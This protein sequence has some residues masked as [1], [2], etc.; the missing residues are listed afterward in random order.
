MKL[1][2]FGVAKWNAQK[3]DTE[4]V[5]V[6]K[7]PCHLVD[8]L[9][10]GDD[11]GPLDVWPYR[12]QIRYNECLREKL[13]KASKL[14]RL[15]EGEATGK[16]HECFKH[17]SSSASDHHVVIRGDEEGGACKEEEGGKS[18]GVKKREMKGS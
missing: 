3:S 5:R 8:W 1:G 12:N 6:G 16:G 15:R 4:V 18:E 13:K 7:G 11:D 14:V 2:P 17:V 10:A 9:V